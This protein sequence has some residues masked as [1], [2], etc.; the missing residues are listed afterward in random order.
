MLRRLWRQHKQ[1]G[2]PCRQRRHLAVHSEVHADRTALRVITAKTGEIHLLHTR[3][4]DSDASEH[5][6]TGA[7]GHHRGKAAGDRSEEQQSLPAKDTHRQ[8][9]RGGGG[10]REEGKGNLNPTK[11]S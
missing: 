5:R 2:Y 6:G 1:S 11:K 8:K 3:S 10:G 9:G 4:R 7:P